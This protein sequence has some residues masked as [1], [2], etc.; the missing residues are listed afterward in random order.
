MW[1]S[2]AAASVGWR[3]TIRASGSAVRTVRTSRPGPTPRRVLA[4]DL[5][6][7]NEDP[8][9]DAPELLRRPLAALP[10]AVRGGRIRMRADAGYFA[11]Q[12]ARAALFTGIELAIGA[13]GS[14]HCGGCST[15]SPRAV[16]LHIR[17]S[18]DSGPSG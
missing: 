17:A 6:A 8:R 4:A 14:P 1:R 2:T 18:P 15:A 11:G 16:V 3:S 12:L 9:R 7:G 13:R 10:A 5:L